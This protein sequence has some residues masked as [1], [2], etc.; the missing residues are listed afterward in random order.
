[1]NTATEEVTSLPANQYVSNSGPLDWA[2]AA[3]S[4][5]GLTVDVLRVANVWAVIALIYGHIYPCSFGVRLQIK[6]KQ[7]KKHKWNVLLH[8]TKT[9]P[10]GIFNDQETPVN[11]RLQVV[12]MWILNITYDLSIIKNCF[13]SPDCVFCLNPD[14]NHVKLNFFH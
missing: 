13:K 14:L 3:E 11:S 12:C 7:K 10:I 6:K 8:V 9:Q 1:M 5:A 2:I 4:K